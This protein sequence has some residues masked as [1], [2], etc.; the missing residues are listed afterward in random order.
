VGLG[1]RYNPTRQSL[2]MVAK[3]VE[4][5]SRTPAQGLC[6]ALQAALDKHDVKPPGPGSPG[7]VELLGRRLMVVLTNLEP[8]SAM[9]TAMLWRLKLEAGD[10]F[11]TPLVIAVANLSDDHG[12]ILEKKLLAAALTLGISDYHILVVPET[13]IDHP[14]HRE[15]MQRRE[16]TIVEV[17]QRLKDFTGEYIEL[18]IMAG[19]DG[20][21]AAIIDQLR[22]MGPWPLVGK[23]WRIKMYSG[24]HSVRHMSKMDWAAL[25]EIMQLSDVCLVD[26]SRFLFFGGKKALPCTESLTTF[27]MED[28]PLKLNQ[29]APLLAGALKT[30]NDDFNARLIYPGLKLFKCKQHLGEPG[31][32][33]H[34][35]INRFQE[36]EAGFILDDPQTIKAYAEGIYSDKALFA[37][38]PDFKRSIIVAYAFDGCDSPLTD[39]II[40]LFEWLMERNPSAITGADKPGIW[41]IDVRNG[42]T[43]VRE[44]DG[45][46]SANPMATPAIQPKMLQHSD[47]GCIGS[48]RDALTDYLVKHLHAIY[49]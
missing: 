48:M 37:K 16:S 8:G 41:E 5:L 38:V 4:Q 3:A 28:F 11:G 33:D 25:H 17:C 12:T 6:Q 13:G 31:K 43:S 7:S 22:I 9:A 47:L 15:L 39:S 30:F 42:Y 44:S 26:I 10:I 21:L 2:R 27:V 40:F 23:V 34:D 49:R 29:C 14:R 19:G 45:T 18:Y 24:S 32:L 46:I 35:E 1:L 20:N 36:I